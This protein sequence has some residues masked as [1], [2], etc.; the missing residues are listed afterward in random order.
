MTNLRLF[1]VACASALAL[2]VN[3]CASVQPPAKMVEI[4][5]AGTAPEPPGSAVTNLYQAAVSAIERRD[6]P[7]A[8]DL[9]QDARDRA[10]QD[11]RVLNAFGVVYDKLGRFDL[12]GRYYAQAQA[13]DPGSAI[14]AENRAYSNVLQGK[15]PLPALASQEAAPPKAPAPAPVA[16]RPVELATAPAPVKPISLGQVVAAPA[17]RVAVAQVPQFAP[18]PA[19]AAQPPVVATAQA[20][21]QQSGPPRSPPSTAPLKL[22]ALTSGPPSPG[23]APALQRSAVTVVAASPP[24]PRPLSVSTPLQMASI[25]PQP[26]LKALAPSPQRTVKLAQLPAAPIETMAFSAPKPLPAQQPPVA[27]PMT[28]LAVRTLGPAMVVSSLSTRSVATKLATRPVQIADATT[29][30]KVDLP[31]FQVASSLQLYAPTPSRPRADHAAPRHAEP[32]A[33]PDQGV[34]AQAAAASIPPPRDRTFATATAETMHIRAPHSVAPPPVSPQPR[35]NAAHSPTALA[36]NA[37]PIARVSSPVMKPVSWK[38]P[39]N[40]PPAAA[41]PAQHPAR[42]G[43]IGRPLVIVDASG[44][45]RAAES[46]RLQLVRR[47]WTIPPARLQTGV[48]RSQTTIRFASI[49]AVVAR[50]LANSLRIPV[51]LERCGHTCQGVSLILGAD[52]RLPTGTVHSGS[53]L[54]RLS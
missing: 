39:A 10:P 26:A 23:P 45:R 27:P 2:G 54:R 52:A 43:Y 37:V 20:A 36:A 49:H 11:A 18:A 8:L 30:R 17:A 31:A 47:G 4:R 5:P 46:V 22:A 14:V 21:P 12:S 3:G 7:R 32:D 40:L 15:A 9:L 24:P 41:A 19:S 50:A 29:F 13:A 51:R 42:S 1:N 38:P 25:Q 6:Y 35:T 44:N 33:V 53:G 16:L 28:R 48:G 34:P